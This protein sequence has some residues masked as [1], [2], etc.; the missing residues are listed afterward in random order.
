MGKV[1]WPNPTA[2]FRKSH[3]MELTFIVAF[4][5]SIIGIVIM[6]VLK[7]RELSMGK[8]SVIARLGER[9]D[10]TFQATW[11]KVRYYFAHVNATNAIGSVQWLAFHF[12]TLL[13]QYQESLLISDHL[14]IFIQIKG[15]KVV[16][17]L[18]ILAELTLILFNKYFAIFSCPNIIDLSK[19]F[20][21][22]FLYCFI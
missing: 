14:L 9:T 21:Q 6:L 12:L 8:Q 22:I 19:L 20:S 13:N 17:S 16:C 18:I 3:P 1:N 11:I 15:F 4:Y 2:D 5:I 7:N 10:S